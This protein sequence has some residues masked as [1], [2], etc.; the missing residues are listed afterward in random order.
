VFLSGNLIWSFK[1]H[2]TVAR[3][4]TE[5]EYRGLAMVAAEVVEL[6]SLFGELGIQLPIPILWCDNVGA[7]FL[8]SNPAFHARTK[9][10][11]LDYPFVR[12][13][14]QLVQISTLRLFSRPVGRCSY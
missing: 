6:G 2:A 11:E 4:S 12:E 3:S 5:A 14:W 9:H 13:K 1:K 8:T 7:A 10:I